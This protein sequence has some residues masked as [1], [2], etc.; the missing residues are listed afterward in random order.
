[1]TKGACQVVS[2]SSED[3]GIEP[4]NQGRREV[5]PAL[6]E[7]PAGHPLDD[8]VLRE[9]R[10]LQREGAPDLLDKV[11]RAYVSETPTLL[12]KL[13]HAVE[14][15][16][17]AGICQAAHALKSSSA[18]IGALPLAELFKKMEALAK[19]KSLDQVKPVFA[20]ISVE[21]E[22]VRNALELEMSG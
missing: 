2:G 19:D 18:N 3:Q 22:R 12:E 17:A 7:P 15:G 16:D 6:E 20:H 21:F 4:Q 14:Q 8:R 9:I 13:A 5:R 1:V 11:M 10:A